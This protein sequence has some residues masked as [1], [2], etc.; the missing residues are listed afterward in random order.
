MNHRP[1]DHLVKAACA[2]ALAVAPTILHADTFSQINLVSNEPG[3]AL[4]TDPNL[5]NPWGLSNS[6]TSPFWVSDQG[7][8]LAT[9]YTGTRTINSTVV[10]I[11][12]GTLGP[13]VPPERSSTPAPRA[14]FWSELLRQASSSTPSTAP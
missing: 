4:V 5:I 13:A 12:P 10:T 6:A 1:I 14:D 11:P 8:G 2:I 3:L 9:L 7:S